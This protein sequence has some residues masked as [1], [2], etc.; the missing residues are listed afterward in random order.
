MTLPEF[1]VVNET[2]RY[3]RISGSVNTFP[4]RLTGIL[5]GRTVS[6]MTTPHEGTA[7][8][9]PNPTSL[10]AGNV[11]AELAR[12]QISYGSAAQFIGLSDS[13]FSRSIRGDRPWTATEL[14]ELA[15]LMECDPS[16]LYGVPT[17]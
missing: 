3:G 16:D 9:R 13:T 11:R 8:E 17:P 4:S 10:I 15:R 12:R 7:S 6:G 2:G 14:A 5:A 1:V